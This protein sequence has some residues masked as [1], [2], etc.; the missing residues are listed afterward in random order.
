M[1][2]CDATF[3][4]ASVA[5]RTMRFA[6]A[7]EASGTVRLYLAAKFSIGFSGSGETPAVA[8]LIGGA[9]VLAAVVADIALH[10]RAVGVPDQAVGS[11]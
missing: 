2:G 9:I 7:S 8:T 6:S 11:L 5:R 3:C 1:A 10:A 4:S